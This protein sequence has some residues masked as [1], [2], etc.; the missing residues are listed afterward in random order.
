MTRRTFLSR[1]GIG[2]SA[3]L[4]AA[5]LPASLF[6]QQTKP[7]P[8]SGPLTYNGKPVVYDAACPSNRVYFLCPQRGPLVLNHDGWQAL[9]SPVADWPAE[10]PS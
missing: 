2:V 3:V 4:A 9:G 10:F 5:K 7:Q 1:F 8:F 6:T